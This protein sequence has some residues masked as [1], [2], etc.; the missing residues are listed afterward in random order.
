MSYTQ[1]INLASSSVSS[2]DRVLIIGAT[3]W[4][5]R[6]VLALL[7]H[8]GAD[9]LLISSTNNEFSLENVK[10]RSQ[11][12][13]QNKIVEFS[14][15][16]V[17][18]CAFLTRDFL[19]KMTLDKYVMTNQTLINNLLFVAGLNSVSRVITISS[20]AAV[21]AALKDNASV[22]SDPYGMLKL[23][24]E[25]QLAQIAT[26][27]SLHLVVAR[28][29]SVSGSLVRKPKNYAFS[30]LILQAQKG[31]VSISS[32]H[33]VWRR[34][35]SAEEFLAVAVAIS[36]TRS[37][38]FSSGGELIEVQDL[39]KVVIEEINPNAKLEARKSITASPSHY[40]SD[41]EEWDLLCGE[42]ELKTLDI[43]Q[44]IH[45]VAEL[46]H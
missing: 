8:C 31:E 9:F 28:A 12:W 33:E 5:G 39:A 16:I 35:C 2:S 13:D 21:E 40:Y 36:E 42:L 25:E 3:G 45:L 30:D 1:A 32:T 34:Y 43:R 29:W 15:T 18:D 19:L 27:N 37:C 10:Y 20:G 24:L 7:N 23:Q 6:T 44:Q 17:I 14:P 22:E 4:F 38:V 11:V 26:R 46:L 41:N